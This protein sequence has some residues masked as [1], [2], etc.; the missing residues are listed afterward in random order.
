MQEIINESKKMNK[1]RTVVPEVTI[2]VN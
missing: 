2:N 1:F